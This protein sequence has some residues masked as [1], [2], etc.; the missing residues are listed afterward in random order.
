MIHMKKQSSR[1]A[2]FAASCYSKTRL[3][4]CALATS[5]YIVSEGSDFMTY[6]RDNYTS[7]SVSSRLTTDSYEASNGSVYKRL[8]DSYEECLLRR[9]CFFY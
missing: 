7:Y 9:L 1:A 4:S 8:T 5:F 3:P 6:V 2:I